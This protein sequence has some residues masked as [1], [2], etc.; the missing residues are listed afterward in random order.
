MPW[1]LV[2]F[3]EIWNL[4]RKTVRSC[5]WNTCLKSRTTVNVFG[6][7]F[8]RLIS[9]PPTESPAQGE[10]RPEIRVAPGQILRVSCL[11]CPGQGG[12]AAAGWG[13][14]LGPA[15]PGHSAPL[16]S[17]GGAARGPRPVRRPPGGGT[18]GIRSARRPLAALRP[19]R[20]PGNLPL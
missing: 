9:T 6:S 14:R 16:G 20:P 17:P 1:H 10:P 3:R 11:L 18:R 5:R 8:Q 2:P 19:P 4:R 13:G 15:A 7:E 12:G